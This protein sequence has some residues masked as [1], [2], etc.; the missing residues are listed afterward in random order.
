MPMKNTLQLATPTD[1]EIVLTRV[2]EAPRTMVWEAMTQ[3]EL[4]RRWLF[5]PPG[6][7][8]ITCENDQRVGGTFRWTWRGPNGVT[9][10]ATGV[11]REVVAPERVV[12]TEVFEVGCVPQAN[13]KLATLVL[14]ERDEKTLLTLTLLFASKEERDG[15]LVSGMERGVAASYERLDELFR[16]SRTV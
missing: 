13:E 1:R 4:L 5:G 3:P 9:M 12:R 6:W 14:T 7:E 8:M 2:F 10:S 15:A 11:Y 16:S